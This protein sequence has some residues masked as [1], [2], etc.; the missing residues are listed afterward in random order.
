MD[1]FCVSCAVLVTSRS[2]RPF[3][4]TM[5]QPIR[6]Y[7]ALPRVSLLVSLS[8]EATW[9]SKAGSTQSYRIFPHHSPMEFTRRSKDNR[10]LDSSIQWNQ[11]MPKVY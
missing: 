3:M 5:S 7:S 1:E 10:V 6:R 9:A 8:P 11:E 2:L 4:K